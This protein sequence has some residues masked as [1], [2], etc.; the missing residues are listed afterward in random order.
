[1]RFGGHTFAHVKTLVS[2][3]LP[4]ESE[5]KVLELMREQRDRREFP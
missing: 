2:R 5:L 1:M 3:K 4:K